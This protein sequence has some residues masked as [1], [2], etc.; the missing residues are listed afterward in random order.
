MG[1][2]VARPF[3]AVA[4]RVGG[5]GFA[6]RPPPLRNSFQAVTPLAQSLLPSLAL[7]MEAEMREYFAGGG[8]VISLLHLRL[9]RGGNES[10]GF[11]TRQQKA[12][13]S[14]TQRGRKREIRAREHLFLEQRRVV[15]RR[16]RV[17]TGIG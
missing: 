2:K 1:C 13:N 15:S 5:V 14:S 10:L 17:S 8:S 12:F 16:R 7:K 3:A 6:I 9:L 11:G 4:R